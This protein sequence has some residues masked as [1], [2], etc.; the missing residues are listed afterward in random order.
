MQI[1]T[2]NK[3]KRDRVVALLNVFGDA[4]ATRNDQLVNMVIPAINAELNKIFQDDPE[5]H[6][7]ENE[8]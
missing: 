5:N 4:K 8:A 2:Q 7:T 3:E 6:P 1:S